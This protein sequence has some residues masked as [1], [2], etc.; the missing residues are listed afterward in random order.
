MKTKFEVLRHI[1][2]DDLSKSHMLRAHSKKVMNI[3][4]QFVNE[5]QRNNLEMMNQRLV[6]LGE[7]HHLYRARKEDFI[8]IQLQFINAIRPIVIKKLNTI[9]KEKLIEISEN[10][11]NAL[12]KKKKKYEGSFQ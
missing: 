9:Q 6:K 7:R 4:E 3:I 11:V 10:F 1:A 5:I 2:V 12:G 8:I